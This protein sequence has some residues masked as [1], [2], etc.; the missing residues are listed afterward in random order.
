MTAAE[1]PAEQQTG[2]QPTGAVQNA[3]VAAESKS[4]SVAEVFEEA[5]LGSLAIIDKQMAMDQVN[6]SVTILTE[7]NS[8][9]TDQGK[10]DLP[11]VQVSAA[12]EDYFNMWKAAH[13]MKGASSN[14][15]ILRVAEACKIVEHT[16]KEFC[17]VVKAG[18]AVPSDRKAK[19]LVHVQMLEMQ[20][21][22]YNKEF[23]TWLESL[24]PDE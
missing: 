16:G 17:E 7:L 3:P 4:L 15:G 9:L 18:N 21:E 24:P 6:N 12:K 10:K 19:L 13:S 2:T 14:L 8:M 20:W 23:A 22:E 5:N 11:N 1:A